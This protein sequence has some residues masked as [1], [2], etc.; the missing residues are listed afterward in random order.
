[1]KR[2]L[3]IFYPDGTITVYEEGNNCKDFREKDNSV[4]YVQLEN[5]TMLMLH[6]IPFLI[7]LAKES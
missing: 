2:T 1:M 6:N 3:I 7:R 4:L 5:G